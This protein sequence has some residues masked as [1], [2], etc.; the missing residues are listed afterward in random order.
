[1]NEPSPAEKRRQDA[2]NHVIHTFG[3]AY[4]FEQRARGPKTR[5]KLLAFSG[6]ALPLVLGFYVTVFGRDAPQLETAVVIAGCVAGAQGVASLWAL[7]AKWDDQYSASLEG[8]VTN[9][10][11]ASRFKE[12]ASNPPPD[13]EVVYRLLRTELSAREAE[14]H[15]L[16]LTDKEK[17]MGLRAGL[18]ELERACVSCKKVPRS[19]EA[20]SCD[21]C[22]NF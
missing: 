6:L 16:L 3:T 13:E 17:R 19:L 11:L 8:V 22:G 14:D 1:M 20:S 5:L 9:Y 18:R 21:V 12:Y 7:V 2:W 10:R 15:K 4:V